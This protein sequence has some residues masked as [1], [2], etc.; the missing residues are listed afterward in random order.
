MSVSAASRA[1]AQN[2]RCGPRDQPSSS[3]NV[4]R[5]ARAPSL[6]PRFRTFS[7]MIGSSRAWQAGQALRCAKSPPQRAR[8]AA[9]RNEGALGVACSVGSSGSPCRPPRPRAPAP[10][11][12]RQQQNADNHQ[13][14]YG[15]E[16]KARLAKR[17]S[18]FV[19]TFQPPAALYCVAAPEPAECSFAMGRELQIASRNPSEAKLRFWRAKSGAEGPLPAALAPPSDR[20]AS[21]RR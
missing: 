21:A 10:I 2:C 17:N 7:P 20:H 12:A 11:S 19:I 16:K 3:F 14:M 18:H 13:H 5:G 1:T 9:L 4:A 8:P 6:G 15:N